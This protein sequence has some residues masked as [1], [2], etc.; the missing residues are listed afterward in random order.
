MLRSKSSRVISWLLFVGCFIGSCLFLIQNLEHFI[1]SDMASDIL[2]AELLAEEGKLLSKNWYYSTE[3]FV[4]H[5]YLLLVPLMHVFEDWYLVRVVASILSYMVMLASAYYVCCQLKSKHAFPFV[6]ILCMIPLSQP[7][8]DNVL[9]GI[10]YVAYLS[11]S[12]ALFGMTLHFSRADKNSKKSLLVILGG[13]LAF[14]VG[15]G[16]MRLLL[17]FG[18]PSVFAAF[19]L[20]LRR[21]ARSVRETDAQPVKFALIIG[22]FFCAML[23]GC[24]LNVAVLSK[25][26]TFR[27]YNNLSFLDI[28]FPWNVLN[29]L[30]AFWGYRAGEAFSTVLLHNGVAAVLIVMV[31][32][33]VK[34][35]WESD[36]SFEHQAVGAFYPIGLGIF[37]LLFCCTDAP[38]FQTY[39]LPLSIFGFFLLAVLAGTEG[40]WKRWQKV[41]GWILVA[42]VICCGAD[43]YFEQAK[44]DETEE[45][46]DIVE[47]LRED[48]YEAGY[49]TF[50]DGNVLGELSDGE[51][52]MYVFLG[53]D[54]ADIDHT[55]KWLQRK[56]HDTEPPEGRVFV[57]IQ[58]YKLGVYAISDMLSPADLVYEGEKY[59]VYGYED[60]DAMKS[61]METALGESQYY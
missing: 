44:I 12:I 45:L 23:M 19:I 55:Y 10:H 8:F 50:W 34:Q 28:S 37:L 26:Y 36:A 24:L 2:L 54:V 43:A 17:T 56:S 47:Y 32:I 25:Q 16:G 5:A 7:Y 11:S 59:L 52:E 48:G 42:V 3:L 58:G 13:G 41:I 39:H 1:N 49:G 31:A 20:L 33:A 14:A 51:F 4:V 57:I 18:L 46:R 15:V 38:Y 61:A 27:N 9:I 40:D 30:L 6:G 60:Y 35:C 53:E 22:I 29:D 21:K